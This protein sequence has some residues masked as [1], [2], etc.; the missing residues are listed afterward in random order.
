MSE[1]YDVMQVCENGHKITGCYNLIPERRKDFFDQCGEK[2][3]NACPNCH[4]QIKGE[5]LAEWSSSFD[6]MNSVPVP[7]YC[8]SCGEAYP[9]TEKNG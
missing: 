1:K 6:A 3:L 7:L 5:L 2:T 8:P 4:K 9:W